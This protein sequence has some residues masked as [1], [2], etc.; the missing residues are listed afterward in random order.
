ML[1]DGVIDEDG[2]V[3][4]DENEE[5]DADMASA[6]EIVLVVVG[7]KRGHEELEFEQALS[8]EGHVNL[9]NDQGAQSFH[10]E[11]PLT[12]YPKG[13]PDGCFK[14]TLSSEGTTGLDSVN[15]AAYKRVIHKNTVNI[16]QNEICCA[17]S[18]GMT[19]QQVANHWQAV[20]YQLIANEC[21]Y[22]VQCFCRRGSYNQTMIE[23]MLLSGPDGVELHSEANH[24]YDRKTNTLYFGAPEGVTVQNMSCR[25]NSPAAVL[26]KP[27]QLGVQP[28]RFARNATNWSAMAQDLN[29]KLSSFHKDLAIA[30]LTEKIFQLVGNPKH[31]FQQFISRGDAE[32]FYKLAKKRKE[33]LIHVRFHHLRQSG[34]SPNIVTV[35]RAQFNVLLTMK[36]RTIS[37]MREG[38]SKEEFDVRIKCE[39]ASAEELLKIL[40][41]VTPDYVGAAQDASASS[42]PNSSRFNFPHFPPNKHLVQYIFSVALCIVNFIYLPKHEEVISVE[43]PAFHRRLMIASEAMISAAWWWVC[44]ELFLVIAIACAVGKSAFQRLR[45]GIFSVL[46]V[47]GVRMSITNLGYYVMDPFLQSH[48]FNTTHFYYADEFITVLNTTVI[49]DNFGDYAFQRFVAAPRTATLRTEHPSENTINLAALSMKVCRANCPSNI[50]LLMH[51]TQEYVKH[52]VVGSIKVGNFFEL[53]KISTTRSPI[54][55]NAS[56]EQA[57]LAF[58]GF[59]AQFPT[60]ID[61][62]EV[63]ILKMIENAKPPTVCFQYF[64]VQFVLT[65]FVQ[66]VNY[67][68]IHS[69]A[70]GAFQFNCPSFGK[71]KTRTFGVFKLQAQPGL[72]WNGSGV[73]WRG[74]CV[75][76][77]GNR[78]SQSK[79]A[80][81]V[82]PALVPTLLPATEQCLDEPEKPDEQNH[83]EQNQE[84]LVDQETDSEL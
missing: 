58:D 17:L 62:G 74:T 4:F 56:V 1:D 33:N 5:E 28:G 41:L 20:K 71:N 48:A 72:T 12:R 23:S 36:N 59:I 68:V 14:Y 2:L 66:V 53:E 9:T 40:P 25:L 18:D 78:A 83:V 38:E 52:G 39:K 50:A 13:I 63:G 24:I 21:A 81:K 79:D 80:P 64:A 61:C 46:T 65:Y 55:I 76:S 54:I 19:A 45:L 84:Q 7:H 42:T 75:P 69:S 60:C 35:S 6:M 47:L 29:D 3:L 8:E 22:F 16:L 70:G 31:H 44:L 73:I 26:L 43:P 67:V 57:R 27:V 77:V 49:A 34:F 10:G 30:D 11:A 15:R 32:S 82:P 37:K 51:C